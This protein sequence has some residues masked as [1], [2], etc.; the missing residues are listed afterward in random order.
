IEAAKAALA[1]AA[2]TIGDAP[3]ELPDA[4]ALRAHIRPDAA[5]DARASPGPG[6]TYLCAADGNRNAISLIHSLFADM[7]PAAVAHQPGIGLR[8]R[9]AGFTEEEGRPNQLAPGRRPFHT[10]MPGLMLADGGLLGPFGIMGAAMQ[11]QAH[12]Q[13]VRRVVDDGL[14]PQAALDAARFRA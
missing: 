2:R 9:G 8:D 6:T 10:L 11:A 7:D 1:W 13:V 14:D 4:D 3:V 5:L 12:F